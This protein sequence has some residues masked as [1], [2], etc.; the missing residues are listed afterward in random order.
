MKTV[1]FKTFGCRTNFYDTQAMIAS[2]GEWRAAHSE[3]EADAIV[4]NSCSVT[5]NADATVRAF[6]GRMR[7]EK[8]KTKILF[9]G[10]GASRLGKKLLDNRVIDG[11]FGHSEKTNV[12]RFLSADLPFE[13]LGDLERIDDIIINNFAGKIRAF[14][15]IQEGCDF[16]CGYCVIPQVRGRSRSLSKTTI[17]EQIK[18]LADNGFEEFVLTGTNAGGYGRE[19]GENIADLIAQ[20][21]KIL[22]VRRVR[23]GS[24]E[25]I[26]IDDELLDICSAPFMAKHL[27]IALQHTSDQVL[28]AMNRR[29]RVESDRVLLDKIAKLGFA[30]GSDY[31]VGFPNESDEIFSEAL[32][33]LRLLPL[34][35]IHIFPFSPREGA[36]AAKIKHNING[37]VINERR[38]ALQELIMQKRRDFYAKNRSPLSILIEKNNSGLDQFFT[39]ATVKS[40]RKLSGWIETKR[41]TIGETGAIIC[42]I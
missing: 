41:Y 31:I 39:R 24:I 6:V 10:C 15:K 9:T 42:E 28:T 25:P 13:R 34:T 4:V 40:D 20:I 11:V 36:E 17:L 19:R 33:N 23:L 30:I 21:G 37:A 14:I 35:H 38:K 8:P 5:N 29:N 7:R 1:Y 22:G 18:I 3:G 2:L 12:D 16:S 26:Q 27:H 32:D